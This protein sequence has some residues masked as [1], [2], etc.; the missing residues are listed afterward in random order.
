[1]KK[2]E[3]IAP[4]AKGEM[5]SVERARAF[6]EKART[7]DEVKDIRDKAEAVRRYLRARGAATDSQNDAAEIRLRAERRIGELTREIPKAQPVAGPGRGNKTK[8]QV[9][10]SFSK[11]VS[12]AEQGIK[13][14]EAKRFEVLASIPQKRFDEHVAEVRAKGERITTHGAQRLAK[15]DAKKDFASKL[16]AKPIPIIEGRFDVIVSD[17]PWQYQKRAEDI[18]HR[19]RN[20]YPDMD[21]DAI[22]ALPV[23]DRAEDNCV[24]WLWTTNAFMR[25]AFRVLD[26]WGF[27]EKTILTWVKDR[28]GT[29][30]W[31]RGKTEHCILAVRGKPIVQLTNQTTELRAP[32]REHS[33]K[34]DEFY[35]LV[36]ALCPGTKLDM[37]AREPREGWA[38]WGAETE[39]F[40]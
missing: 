14:T 15:A 38:T 12:L 33:R 35:A 17:P 31:L 18:T 2:S 28:M 9:G 39:K 11:R 13:P 27:R 36:D 6:L 4:A 29:G 22:C 10:P 1:V 5:L 24:L 25:D 26:A 19:G 8:V 30:D 3:A 40:S 7:V 32:L 20:P 23:A 21:T 34:P 37:F 16:R